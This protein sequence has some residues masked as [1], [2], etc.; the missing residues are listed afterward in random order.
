MV[1]ALAI[2]YGRIGHMV[3]KNSPTPQLEKL[4]SG[5]AYAIAT[6]GLA[7]LSKDYLVASGILPADLMK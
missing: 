6:I 7:M 3:M 4:N 1:G 2:G 5:A